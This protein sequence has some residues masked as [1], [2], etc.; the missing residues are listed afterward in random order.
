MSKKS[1]LKHVFYYLP[2]V[3]TQVT[4]LVQAL[5]PQALFIRPCSQPPAFPAEVVAI[6]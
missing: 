4:Y 2:G 6:G 3:A 1:F 5:A